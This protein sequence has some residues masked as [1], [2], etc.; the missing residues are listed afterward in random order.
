MRALLS[1]FFLLHSNLL[2]ADLNTD[3]NISIEDKVNQIKSTASK[4]SKPGDNK[5][6]YLSKDYESGSKSLQ[7]TG[8]PADLYLIATTQQVGLPKLKLPE[9]TNLTP[10]K[11][12]LGRKLFFDRRLSHTDTIS[13]SYTHLRAH[14]T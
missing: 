12:N 9:G 5:D 13:V 14:E 1:I 2:L 8:K 10:E 7:R 3:S 11:I 4:L 6:G